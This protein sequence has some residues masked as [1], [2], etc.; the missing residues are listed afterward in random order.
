MVIAGT[1]KRRRIRNQSWSGPRLAE[2]SWKN[3]G[4]MK[5]AKEHRAT[6][7]VMNTYPVGFANQLLRSRRKIAWMIG[8]AAM[9]MPAP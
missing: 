6:K 3:F 1:K 4:G 9:I 2:F 8:F 5:R 7:S